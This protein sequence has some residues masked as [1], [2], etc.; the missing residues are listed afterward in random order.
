MLPLYGM[1]HGYEE[2][3]AVLLVTVLFIGDALLQVP[4]GWVSDKLGTVRVHLACGG[5]FVLMLAGL[6]FSYG[7]GWVWAN[8]FLLGAV[9]GSIYTLALVRAGKQFSVV[10]LVAIN[11]LFGVLWGVGSFSGPLVSGSLMQWYGR[12]GLIAVLGLLG[13][14][15]LAA[16]TL[17]ATQRNA[18]GQTDPEPAE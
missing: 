1:A 11:A 10:N 12:D 16:N 7:T 2:Q 18:A 5:L 15:F 8:V 6:P 14:L 17:S 3:L 9:A 4:L 13:L